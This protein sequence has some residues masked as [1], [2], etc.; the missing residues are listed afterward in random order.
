MLE[1]H[2]SAYP[3]GKV[4]SGFLAAKFNG[5]VLLTRLRHYPTLCSHNE[6]PWNIM[7]CKYLKEVHKALKWNHVVKGG[8]NL[9]NAICFNIVLML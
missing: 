7:L 3:A 8:I 1:N 5:F 2:S 9:I 4:G 6:N